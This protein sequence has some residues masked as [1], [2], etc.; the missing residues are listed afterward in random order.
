MVKC[1][2]EVEKR[3]ALGFARAQTNHTRDT[4]SQRKSSPAFFY[5]DLSCHK[6]SFK[7]VK[8]TPILWL[9]KCH[10]LWCLQIQKLHKSKFINISV[11]ISLAKKN[12]S[13]KNIAS[14]NLEWHNLVYKKPKA[15]K[16]E[17]KVTYAS[18]AHNREICVC[19]V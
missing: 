3:R 15:W 19:V 10:I 13:F 14:L 18:S 12:K 1:G 9:D 5:K 4:K 17:K 11:F 16:K 8:K 2:A 7:C 6:M